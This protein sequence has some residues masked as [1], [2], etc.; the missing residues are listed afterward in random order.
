MKCYWASPVIYFG[1]Y[2]CNNI[3]YIIRRI[4]TVCIYVFVV[5][6]HHLSS[7]SRVLPSTSELL[8]KIVRKR[9]QFSLLIKEGI[10]YPNSAMVM[11]KN[12]KAK[13]RSVLQIADLNVF[14]WEKKWNIPASDRN[15]LL[16]CFFLKEQPMQT[17]NN[18]DVQVMG[19]AGTN[20]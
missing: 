3:F 4:L 1:F 17:V 18:W 8:L 5:I 7:K 2:W 6:G 13:M 19:S 16:S 15:I 9:P 11:W 14:D 12:V 10:H 20:H